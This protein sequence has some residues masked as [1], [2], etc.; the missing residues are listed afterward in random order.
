MDGRW[1]L[2]CWQKHRNSLY[3][4]NNYDAAHTYT[5]TTAQQ[6]LSSGNNKFITIQTDYTNPLTK[7]TKLDAGL[8][9]Q[10]NKIVK[11]YGIREPVWNRIYKAARAKHQ[12]SQYK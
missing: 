2:F 6:Q 8:R 7:T 10:I 9:A 1:K 11:H 3:T 5:G 4:N 12:L